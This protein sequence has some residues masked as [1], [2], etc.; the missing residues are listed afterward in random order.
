MKSRTW[1]SRDHWRTLAYREYRD[2]REWRHLLALNPSYDIRTQPAAG[3]GVMVTGELGAGEPVPS[4]AGKR[5]M[6][7]APGMTL[8]PLTGSRNLFETTEPLHFPWDSEAEYMDRL[9]AYTG[10]AL[11][12]RDRTN[13]FGIDSRQAFSDS[14]R[15]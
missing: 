3:V 9:G 11:M 14:Q 2:S 12:A 1:Q 6:L 7:K 10:M 15:G 13:G 4:L 5:G 8:E